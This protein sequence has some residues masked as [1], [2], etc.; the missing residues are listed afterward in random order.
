[1]ARNFQMWKNWALF[2][3]NFFCVSCKSG[4]QNWSP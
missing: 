1:V 3:P 4:F 2:F